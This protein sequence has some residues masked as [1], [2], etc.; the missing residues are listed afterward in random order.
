MKKSQKVRVIIGS[1]GFYTTV[2]AIRNGLFSFTS[3]QLA[4]EFALEALE[5]SK[6]STGLCGQWNGYHI[7]LDLL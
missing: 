5:I 1:I 3:Q 2:K 6:N 7:Q 4:V